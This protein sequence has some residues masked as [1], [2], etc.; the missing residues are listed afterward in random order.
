MNLLCRLF[1]DS[2][3]VD[4]VLQSAVAV[5]LTVQAVVVAVGHKKLQYKLACLQ[6]SRGICH[7]DHAGHCRC[8]AGRQQSVCSIDFDYAYAANT[9]VICLLKMAQGGDFHS[10]NPRYI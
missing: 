4:Q 10:M 7:Y 3:F 1:E 8:S 2:M 6:D 5:G 9:F